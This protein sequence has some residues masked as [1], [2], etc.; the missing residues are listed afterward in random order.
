MLLASS[1][2]VYAVPSG[3][4]VKNLPALQETLLQSLV[5]EDSLEEEMQPIPGFLAGKSQG[6]RS[7]V[8]YS[9]WVAQSQT[10]LSD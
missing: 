6:Q 7:L 4:G 2:T 9:P 3:A 8:G 1:I 5:W 10:Q